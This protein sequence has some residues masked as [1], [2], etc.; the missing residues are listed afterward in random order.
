MG[1]NYS[2]RE[3]GSDYSEEIRGHRIKETNREGALGIGCKN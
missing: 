3:G 1:C 2:M